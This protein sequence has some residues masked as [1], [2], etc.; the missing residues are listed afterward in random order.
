MDNKTAK[1]ICSNLINANGSD[2]NPIDKIERYI[3]LLLEENGNHNLIG[4]STE[5]SI[6]SRHILDAL[7][8]LSFLKDSKVNNVVDIGSGCGVPAIPLAICNSNQFFTLVEKSPVK[9]NFL[10]KVADLLDL[11][12]VSIKCCKVEDLRL[13]NEN[14]LFISRAFK[15][16]KDT[17][18]ML[19]LGMRECNFLLLKGD[20]VQ[21]E[22]LEAEK[23]YKFSY[24]L[25]QSITGKGFVIE[26]KLQNN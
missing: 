18:D 21:Q 13:K 17:F 1:K 16:I 23:K 20:S 6:W 7:Q 8:L 19:H 5:D 14:V 22:I 15:S 4:R 26:I 24:V 9:Y 2:Y 25:H 3:A 11:Q 12:N 10:C